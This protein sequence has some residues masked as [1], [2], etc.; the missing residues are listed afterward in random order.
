MFQPRA[1]IITHHGEIVELHPQGGIIDQGLG[2]AGGEMT[3][4]KAVRLRA[5]IEAELVHGGGAAGSRH[6]ADDHGRIAGDVSG[7]VSLVDARLG[8]GIAADSV[9]HHHG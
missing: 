2:S 3:S 9:V 4:R 6:V 7:Q 8:V 1:A 5:D